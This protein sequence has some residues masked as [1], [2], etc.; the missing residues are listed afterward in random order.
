M[1]EE[2]IWV[3]RTSTNMPEENHWGLC[4]CGVFDYL[5]FQF[6]Y[7]KIWYGYGYV[8]VPAHPPEHYNCATRLLNVRNF[9]VVENWCHLLSKFRW[10][11]TIEYWYATSTSSSLQVTVAASI[12]EILRRGLTTHVTRPRR[13]WHEKTTRLKLNRPVWSGSLKI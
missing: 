8:N 4:S 7:I 13:R 3:F 2:F 12:H 6:V 5:V 1:M 9:F 10:S 11:K